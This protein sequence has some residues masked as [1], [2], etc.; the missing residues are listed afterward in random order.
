MISQYCLK[1]PDFNIS[2]AAWEALSFAVEIPNIFIPLAWSRVRAWDWYAFTMSVMWFTLW[3]WLEVGPEPIWNLTICQNSSSPS[4]LLY[5]RKSASSRA[6]SWLLFGHLS[7]ISAFW[8]WPIAHTSMLPSRWHEMCVFSDIW[9]ICDTGMLGNWTT[10]THS[11]FSAS[12]TTILESKPVDTSTLFH[13]KLRILSV[14]KVCVSFVVPVFR[15]KM[16][17][18]WFL[19]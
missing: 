1:F 18:A 3:F 9:T 8:A 4:V 16:Y 10:W 19:A 11:D 17:T 15:S 13:S 2:S 14:C 7:K 12:H 5:R 6:S